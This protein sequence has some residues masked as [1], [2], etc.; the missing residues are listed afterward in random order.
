MAKKAH[1]AEHK[2]RTVKRFQDLIKEYPIVGALDL[3]NMPAPQLQQ[4]RAKLRKDVVILMTKRRLLKIAIENSKANKNG[5]EELEKHLKGM[6]ALLFTKENPF[7][8]FKIIKKNKTKAPAKGGQISPIDIVIK[9]GSTS[10]APGPVISELGKFGLKTGVEGGKVTIRQDTVV[11][12]AGDIIN[13]ALAGLLI[14]FGIEPMEIGLDL[15]AVYENGTIF[16]KDVLNIDEEQFMRNLL[17]ATRWGINLAVEVGYYTKDVVNLMIPK[18]HRDALA[19]ARSQDILTSATVGEVLA[20][21]E[22]QMKSLKT[23][24]KIEDAPSVEEKEEETKTEEAPRGEVKEEPKQEVKKEE[25]KKAPKESGPSPNVQHEQQ[26]AEKLFEELKQK[27]TLRDNGK[28]EVKV[29]EEK[30]PEDII[31]EGVKKQKEK[32]K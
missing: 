11:C 27:G 16:T 17:N 8:L 5:I 15:V 7:K 13:N 19:L 24:A 6:P 28:K 18:A 21:A 10:F 22:R 2:K 1:V 9:A 23:T 26:K 12:K 14:K 4:M 25:V 32:Q 3:E 30:T 29:P 31:A 20:K